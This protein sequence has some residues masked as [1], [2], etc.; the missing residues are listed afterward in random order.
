MN[1]DITN[2]CAEDSSKSAPMNLRYKVLAVTEDVPK[3]PKQPSQTTV[4]VARYQFTDEQGSP[5]IDTL[6]DALVQQK[7]S[8]GRFSLKRSKDASKQ[9]VHY[10][11]EGTSIEVDTN[12]KA[13]NGIAVDVNR[14]Q[15]GAP[16]DT[17]LQVD[18]VNRLNV[19][20]EII[21]G[22]H[23]KGSVESLQSTGARN[24]AALSG[25]KFQV[26]TTK[27]EV[28]LDSQID[29][30]V[31]TY[32]GMNY[33]KDNLAT[34]VSQ[35]AGLDISIPDKATILVFTGFT[36][37]QQQDNTRF[38]G[39]EYGVEYQTKKGVKVYSRIKDSS[40]K[41]GRVYEAGISIDLNR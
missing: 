20:Q 36:R 27:A 8:P 29:R 13:E 4:V 16:I 12:V 2:V 24:L 3:D 41:T 23:V 11:A 26:N 7:D 9:I 22:T 30:D 33:T 31:K 15:A 17:T 34:E 37:R 38:R 35:V 14:G 40:D 25:A 6:K 10:V 32:A 19:K 5:V 21:N 28:R 18:W 39:R 1:F